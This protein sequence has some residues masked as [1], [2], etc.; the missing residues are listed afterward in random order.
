MTGRGA[1]YCAGYGQPGF[2]TAGGQWSDGPDRG[3]GQGRGMGP[4]PGRRRGRGFGGGAFRPP[5]WAAPERATQ[6]WADPEQEATM[7]QHQ[8]ENLERQLGTINERLAELGGK[9]GENT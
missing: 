1:G 6:S 2:V 9:S 8:A 4:G 3:F 5:S 7:L